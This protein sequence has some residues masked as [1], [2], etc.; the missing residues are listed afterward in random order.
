MMSTPSAAKPAAPDFGV[1][2]NLAFGVFKQELHAELA[3]VGFDDVGA[4]FGYVFRLLAQKPTNLRDVAEALSITA[5][6][7]LK[8]VNDMID[9]GYVERQEHP[10]DAR[11]KLLTLTPRA[12][13]AMN[14]AHEFH[15]A[16]ERSL[17]TRVGLRQASAARTALE[18]IVANAERDGSE[19]GI[20][21]RPL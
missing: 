3:R 14:A 4:S 15:E 19:T 16:F 5:P 2:L 12:R 8:I 10:G 7:A 13:Q 1:L 17:A 6:G 11:Q 18:A 20:S 21:L 9:K